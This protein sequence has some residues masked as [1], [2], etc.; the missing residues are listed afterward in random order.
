MPDNKHELKVLMLD[1]DTGFYRMQRYRIGGISARG[2]W[3]EPHVHQAG[4]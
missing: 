4:Y 2:G 1:A 3:S